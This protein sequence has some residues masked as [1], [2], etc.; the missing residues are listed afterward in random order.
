MITVKEIAKM[1]NVSPSTVSNIVN[2]KTNVSE[3]TRQRVL[4]VI[5]ETGYRPNYFASSMRKQNTKLISVVVE[6]LDQFSTTPIVEAAMEYCEKHGYRTILVN[7]RM[8]D[9]WKDTWFHDESKLE[10]VLIPAL[11]EVQSIKVDGV[12]YV[13]GHCRNIRCFP[14]DFPLPL[15]VAYATNEGNRFPSVI[16]DDEKG[17]YDMMKYLISMGH[18]KIGIMAGA[19]D[20]IHTVSRLLGCQKALQEEGIPYNS[21]L[22]VFGGWEEKTGYT[23]AEKLAQTGVTAIWCMNDLMAGGAYEFA[24]KN[25]IEIGRDLS[26]AGYD[27]RQISEFMYPRLTT[28]A[29]PLREIGAISAQTMLTMLA[30]G[31]DAVNTEPVPV[32]CTLMIRDSVKEPASTL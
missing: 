18:R 21:G 15:M 7:L 19:P 31:R 32:P 6:D 29:L 22:T 14:K 10:S 17:G 3:E 8:Y 20:N 2:G 5:K 26:I 4:D 27:N 25:G 28:N 24:H 9:K 16:L 23:C 30:D 13:A 12:I 1:C 11:N